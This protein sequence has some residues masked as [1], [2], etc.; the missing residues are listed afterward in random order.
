MPRFLREK[1][2]PTS[3]QMKTNQPKQTKPVCVFGSSC[4][5]EMG[6]LTLFRI[7]CERVRGGLGEFQSNVYGEKAWTPGLSH[8]CT[9]HENPCHSIS[10]IPR[11]CHFTDNCQLCDEVNVRYILALSQW[12]REHF[13]LVYNKHSMH[14]MAD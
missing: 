7:P 8:A 4:H 5:Q 9:P 10:T 13:I 2:S 6:V 1:A 3:E 14:N 11:V 12:D